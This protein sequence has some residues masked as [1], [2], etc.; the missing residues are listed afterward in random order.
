MLACVLL[1]HQRISEHPDRT[2]F[3]KFNRTTAQHK[4]KNTAGT[5]VNKIL[6]VVALYN[7]VYLGYDNN[8]E[9]RISFCEK[10]NAANKIS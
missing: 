1:H 10:D 9:E 6:F 2:N 5:F 3:A 7:V 4:P 8:D